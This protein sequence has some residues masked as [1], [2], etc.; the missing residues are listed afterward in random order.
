MADLIASSL[1]LAVCV[2]LS[3][4]DFIDER[5]RRFGKSVTSA[6]T[7][8]AGKFFNPP[9]SCRTSDA[10]LLPS[11]AEPLSRNSRLISA[12]YVAT[13]LAINCARSLLAVTSAGLG[14][15]VVVGCGV[16][17]EGSGVD[18]EAANSGAV[19]FDSCGVVSLVCWDDP[20][21]ENSNGDKTSTEE[22]MIR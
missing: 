11:S 8:S 9:S 12:P 3:V 5:R 18:S 6:S 16:A 7:V 4:I 13:S 1:P 2:S 17:E 21:P 15:L 19:D 22:E 14:S 10:F 20:Q